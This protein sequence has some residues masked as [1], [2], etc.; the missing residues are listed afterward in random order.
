MNDASWWERRGPLTAAILGGVLIVVIAAFLLWMGPFA[1]PAGEPTP[2]PTAAAPASPSPSPEPTLGPEPTLSPEPSPDP[3]P[4]PEP[5]PATSP[6]IAPRPSPPPAV[7]PSPGPTGWIEITDFPTYRGS[8]HVESIVAGGP[9]F[10]AV[11][12]GGQQQRGRVW[13]SADGVRWTAA[14]DDQFRGVD[15]RTVVRTGNSL[16]LFGSDAQGWR[17][18]R[19]S[20]GTTWNGVGEL[21]G[22]AGAGIVDIVAVGNTLVA[23]G[24]TRDDVEPA[25][26]RSTDGISWQPVAAPGSEPW[27]AAVMDNTIVV[28]SRFAGEDRS[29]PIYYSTDLGDSWQA[30]TTDF[31]MGEDEVPGLV[32]VAADGRRF[33]AVGYGDTY[34]FPPITARSGDGRSWTS[35][36]PAGYNLLGQVV[37]LRGGGFVAFEGSGNRV[38]VSANGR[39]WTPVA[40][41]VT[42]RPAPP[43]PREPGDEWVTFREVAANRSGVVVAQEWGNTVVVWFGPATLFR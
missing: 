14:P 36:Q 26:W 35:R 37:A 1:P 24:F 8:T 15:F 18:W 2:S 31:A 17:A 16:Y 43:I 27:A 39:D 4:S 9:G 13:T 3:S 12:S 5:S 42:S 10:V 19:S 34:D 25:A 29:H 33:V 11:G 21:S 38:L 30:A 40:P 20:D 22:L 7:S 28:I 41:L 6:T 32:S 23:L